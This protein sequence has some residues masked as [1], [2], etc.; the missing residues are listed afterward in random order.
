[1]DNIKKYL[2]VR[3]VAQ[4]LELSEEWIRDLI[5]KKELKAIKIRQWK[6]SPRDLNNFIKG[7]WNVNK[8]L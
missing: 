8:N 5:S 1:M 7:R 2:T 3:K 6:I 4:K